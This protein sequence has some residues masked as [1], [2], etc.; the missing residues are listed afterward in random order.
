VVRPRPRRDAAEHTLDIKEL[1]RLPGAQGD[2]L[3][4]VQ[5]LPGV[6]RAPFGA[7]QLIVWGSAPGD[8]RVYVDGVLIPRLYH[9]GGVRATLSSEFIRELVFRPGAY[10]ADYGRGL[11]GVVLVKTRPPRGDGLHGSISLDLID[12]TLTLEG[13]LTPKLHVAAGARVSWISAL[14]PL[15][16][17]GGPQLSPF[18]W[19][20]QLLLRYRPT[21]RDDVDAMVFGSTSDIRAVV[22][23]PDPNVAVDI[24]S[25][26]YFGRAL[27]RWTRRF[28]QQTTLTVTPSLG[29]DTF[30]IDTAGQ[31]IGGQALAIRTFQIGYNLRAELVHR[32]LPALEGAFGLDFEGLR[33]QVDALAPGGAPLSGGET[34][35]VPSG[36]GDQIRDA[37]KAEGGYLGDRLFGGGGAAAVREQAVSHLLQAAPYVVARFFLLDRQLLLSPQLR[38]SVDHL[39]GEDGRAPRTLFTPEP[40]LL[41]DANVLPGHLRLKAGVGV[42][43]QPPQGAELS[44]VF[45]NPALGLQTATTYV[46]GADVQITSTLSVSAQGFYKDLRDLVVPDERL[47]YS[48]DGAG[49]VYGGDFLL[50]QELFR[51]FFGWAAYTLSRSERRDRP[52]EPYYPFRFDQTHILTL[53]G[54]YRLPWGLEVGVRFRYVTGNPTTPTV[55]GVRHLDE[56]RYVAISGEKNSQ[57]LPDFHQLDVRIDKTFV[58]RR[59]RL[60]LYLDLQ[61]VYNRSNT[62]YLV[63]GGRQL[64]QVGPVGGLPFFPNLG[65]R[66]DF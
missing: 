31:G 11:G 3:R 53:L 49:R 15:L 18:Y 1:R 42:F 61:N 44:P 12:G 4:G 20:Y 47:G 40:R 32:F 23:D 34:Q 7:G 54:S 65:A 45:G 21:Q 51:N 39:R 36:S 19:D 10:S 13:P 62:E 28:S 46:A 14:L 55:G 48:N 2:A 27:V 25:K 56:G 6:A 38:L 63:Y 43:H 30:T 22:S 17:R 57:R 66:A 59:F 35:G 41:L 26:S 37:G 29:A 64:Y 8:T 5:N 58:F 60:G 33:I 24:R 52:G 9:F 16:T 50:R